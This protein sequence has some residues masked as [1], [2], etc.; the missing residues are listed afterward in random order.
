MRR[1]SKFDLTLEK[2]EEE[3]EEEEEEA[4]E[5]GTRWCRSFA[6]NFSGSFFTLP[7]PSKAVSP[8]FLAKLFSLIKCF[9]IM[10]EIS[11]M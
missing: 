2:E 7:S 9:C 10:Y 4:W 8:V 6:A 1:D 11:I 5:G 3:E